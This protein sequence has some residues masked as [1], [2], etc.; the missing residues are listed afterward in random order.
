MYFCQIRTSSPI[1][2][3]TYTSISDSTEDHQCCRIGVVNSHDI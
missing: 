3:F 2:Y 1:Q